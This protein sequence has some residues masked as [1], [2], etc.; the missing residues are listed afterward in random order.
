MKMVYRCRYKKND[1]FPY[2]NKKKLNGCTY[3]SNTFFEKFFSPFENIVGRKID[4]DDIILVFLIYLLY[5]EK[6][7]DNTTLILCLL[8]ILIG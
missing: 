8:F 1:L 4:F 3:K 2:K 7:N 6:D 5:T